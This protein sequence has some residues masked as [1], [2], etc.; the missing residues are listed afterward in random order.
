MLI[1]FFFL[2]NV[3]L[4]FGQPQEDIVNYHLLKVS[5]TCGNIEFNIN[6]QETE[7]YVSS[8]SKIQN[9]TLQD[10]MDDDNNIRL[11]I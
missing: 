7:I 5:S 4:A 8:P 6:F 9:L 10:S 3:F 11:N 2:I 1:V